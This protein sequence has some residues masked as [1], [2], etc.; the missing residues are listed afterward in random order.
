[1]FLKT[2]FKNNKKMIILHALLK[3]EWESAK[4]RGTYGEDSLKKFGFIHCSPI[5]YMPLVAN[6]HFKNTRGL[7]LLCIDDQKVKAEIKWE[8]HDGF[9]RFYPHIYGLLNFDAIVDVIPFEPNAEGDYYLTE[10][11]EK[12]RVS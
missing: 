4:K 12:Y 3:T 7:V 5:D 8:D 1:M 6:Y 2:T 9:G 10:E 11:M